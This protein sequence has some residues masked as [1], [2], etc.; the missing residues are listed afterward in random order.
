MKALGGLCDLDKDMF[1]RVDLKLN[2]FQ[3]RL[4]KAGLVKAGWE[5]TSYSL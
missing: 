2:P 1:L 4:V 3:V 5:D